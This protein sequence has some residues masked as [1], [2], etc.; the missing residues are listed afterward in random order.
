VKNEAGRRES[1]VGKGT[2]KEYE[3]AMHRIRETRISEGIKQHKSAERNIRPNYERWLSFRTSA[4]VVD[5]NIR[6]E[7]EKNSAIKLKTIFL[8]Q[9]RFVSNVHSALSKFTG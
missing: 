6:G 4:L 5:K 1:H 9:K 2:L 8:L 3:P 7:M